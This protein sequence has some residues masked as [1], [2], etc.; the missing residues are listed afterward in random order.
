MH[1]CTLKKK[2]IMTVTMTLKDNREDKVM[3]SRFGK[4][5][6]F[7]C[8][9]YEEGK[10]WIVEMDKKQRNLQLRELELRIEAREARKQNQKGDV[11]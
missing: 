4:C 11:G 7:E 1:L 3:E 10:C 2:E 6:L 5:D 9:F 8:P